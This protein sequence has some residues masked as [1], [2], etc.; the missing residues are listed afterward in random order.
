MNADGAPP[1]WP[2]GKCSSTT[3][4]GFADARGGRSRH[5]PAIGKPTGQRG[6]TRAQ[7]I[8]DPSDLGHAVHGKVAVAHEIKGKPGNEEIADVIATEQANASPQ[9][10]RKR[11]NSGRLGAPDTSVRPSSWF[12]GIHFSQGSSQSRLARPRTTKKGRQPN[13]AISSPPKSMP[14][15][16]PNKSAA[17]SGSWQC[18]D[19]LPGSSA[20]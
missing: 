17:G 10:D 6:E 4:E 16:G 7:Q 12:V 18:H 2:R 19:A 1:A 11:R 13:R 8:G 5:D 15:P 3:R 14:V 9:A 20:Q